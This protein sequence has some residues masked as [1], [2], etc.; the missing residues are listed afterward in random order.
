MAK[1]TGL[2]KAITRGLTVD[3]IVC[4]QEAA[5]DVREALLELGLDYHVIADEKISP[6]RV[7]ATSVRALTSFSGTQAN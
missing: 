5:E 3:T 6:R 1:L 2:I 4:G 7:Y